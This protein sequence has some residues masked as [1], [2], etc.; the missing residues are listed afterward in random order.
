MLFT[1]QMTKAQDNKIVDFSVTLESNHLWRGL[2]ITDMP[3]LSLQ[4]TFFL[5]SERTWTA[6]FWGGQALS[7]DSDGTHYKEIDYFIQYANEFVSFGLWDL[8][9]TRGADSPDIWNYDEKTTGH[10]I[11]FRSSFFFGESFPLRLEIDAILYGSGDMDVN[12]DQK[13]SMY[14]EVSY[15]LYNQE[16][17]VVNGFVAAGY[18]LNSD[19]NKNGNK[20]LYAEDSFNIVNVG[21]KLSKT[22]K[23]GTWSLPVN[24][25]TMW[26]PATKFSRIQVAINLF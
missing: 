4:T 1:V 13:Y 10:T 3:T 20:S 11:D 21:L 15:P 22:V 12:G 18:A 19:V 6:G 7:R 23:I 25:M 2:I 9:N 16:G 26:N 17:I 24:V 8:F 14:T 5:N